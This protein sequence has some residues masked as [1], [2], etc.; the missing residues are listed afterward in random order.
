MNYSRYS[1]RSD[2][3]TCGISFC[4]SLKELCSWEQPTKDGPGQAD[5][6]ENRAAWNLHQ[7]VEPHLLTV[8]RS[9]L[10]E[11]REGKACMAS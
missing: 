5:C 3:Q 4:R 9:R 6:G 11:G 10:L 1:N 2:L 8:A 7:R